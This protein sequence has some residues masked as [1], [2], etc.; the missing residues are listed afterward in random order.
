MLSFKME[1]ERKWN[2][3]RFTQT[4]LKVVTQQWQRDQEELLARALV[5]LQEAKH[6]H[7]AELQVHREHQ[8]Q[9]DMCSQLRAKVSVSQSSQTVLFSN[10]TGKSLV[11][12]LPHVC[13]W[14]HT[15]QNDTFGQ[16]HAKQTHTGIQLSGRTILYVSEIQ[17]SELQKFSPSGWLFRGAGH[18]NCQSP[19]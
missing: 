5:T 19:N 13:F 3:Q 18:H 10:V 6:A 12:C 4:Q 11:Q 16:K 9:R 17:V 15:F 2:W 1:H 8:Q 14:G 7:Q